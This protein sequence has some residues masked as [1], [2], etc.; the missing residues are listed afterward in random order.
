MMLSSIDPGKEV[1]LRG[2]NGGMGLRSRLHGMGLIPGVTLTV[3]NQKGGGPVIIALKD[4]R[5]AIGHGMAQKI[6]VE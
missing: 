3:L 4:S 1:T 6:V 5:L 2:I